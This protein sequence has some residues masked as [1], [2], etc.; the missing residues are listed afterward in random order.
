MTKKTYVDVLGLQ[1]GKAPE[2][3]A[4]F[5][6]KTQANWHIN[7]TFVTEGFDKL[8]TTNTKTKG[9]KFV[10]EVV[11]DDK[12]TYIHAVST[13]N[14]TDL[15]TVE[16]VTTKE[17][18]LGAINKGLIKN[19]TGVNKIELL[20]TEET[21]SLE[22]LKKSVQTVFPENEVFPIAK[23][24]K[25]LST[26]LL[27]SLSE[28]EDVEEEDSEEDV[29]EPEE[30][31]K[32]EHKKAKKEEKSEEVKTETTEEVSAEE[33]TVEEETVEE[34]EEIVEEE[35]EEEVEEEETEDD[36]EE[37]DEVMEEID[38]DLEDVFED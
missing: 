15:E 11:A 26:E 12:G 19:K 14:I 22:D 37:I 31:P 36:V 2:V 3:V 10:Q 24:E 7:N 13:M 27:K 8:L 30:T 29:S 38:E 17:T 28:D 35:A 9:E 6:N 16:T 18:L 5:S 25:K 32:K 21:G 1:K 34:T 23:I 20:E 4:T 33:E